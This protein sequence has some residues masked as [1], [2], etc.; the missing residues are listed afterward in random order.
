MNENKQ[1]DNLVDAYIGQAVIDNFYEEYNSLPS[2]EELSKEYTFS[3]KHERRMKALFVKE[4]RK[5]YFKKTVHIGRKVAAIFLI[6]IAVFAGMLMIN[7]NVRATVVE[8]IITWQR[9]FVKFLSSN[10]EV[11]GS[12]MMPTYIPT[13]FREGFYEF[14]DG[15]TVIL[16]LNEKGETILFQSLKAEGTLYVDNEDA[17]YD[18]L[19]IDGVSYNILKALETGV[20]N[21]IIW[22]IQG[23][24]YIIR[25][26]IDIE[27]LQ[28][29]ALSLEQTER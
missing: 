4:E 14:V 19:N 11:E 6:F 20:E 13:G 9:E 7:P 24:R 26:T 22:E 2:L 17:V 16:Y 23:W 10:A 15:S 18:V 25:S 28:E 27:S 8:T 5:E 1:S 12:S 29:M 21:T 3:E